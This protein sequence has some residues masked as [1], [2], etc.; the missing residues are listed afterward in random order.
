VPF[1]DVLWRQLKKW[2]QEEVFGLWLA[3]GLIFVLG[4]F[5]GA[6]FWVT[7]QTSLWWADNVRYVMPAEIALLWLVVRDDAKPSTLR[8]TICLVIL[9]AMS[10]YPPI[11]YLPESSAG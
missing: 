6:V 8:W 11:Y 2:R 4:W 1:V 7:D 9:F 5:F 10:M 3:I